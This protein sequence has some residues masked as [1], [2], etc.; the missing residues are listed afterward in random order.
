MFLCLPHSVWGSAHPVTSTDLSSYWV[1]A[2]VR[3]LKL[4]FH[5]GLWSPGYGPIAQGGKCTGTWTLEKLVC[6]HSRLGSSRGQLWVDSFL[7]PAPSQPQ[8]LE[9]SRPR[10]GCYTVIFFFFSHTV[11]FGC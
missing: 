8:G 2:W 9:K 11:N 1:V 5:H 10:V 6:F 7:H 4:S 3:P